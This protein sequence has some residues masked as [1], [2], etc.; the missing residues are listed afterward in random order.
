[1]AEIPGTLTVDN[2]VIADIAG[3]AALESYGVVGMASP[4]L[5]DG[6]A[7]L[8]PAARLRRGIIVGSTEDGVTIDLYIVVESGMNV[9]TVA[10]NLSDAV[11][12]ALTSFAQIDIASI[13]VHVQGVRVRD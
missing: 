4:T 9:T 12:Y 8:L 5:T 11:R 2:A 10:R 3:F 13:Q 6:I 1:M 7:K